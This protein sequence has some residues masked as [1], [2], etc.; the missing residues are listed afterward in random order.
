[1][2]II[3][4]F[5][6]SLFTIG[7]NAQKKTL[8]IIFGD[9]IDKTEV[10]YIE[11]EDEKYHIVNDTITIQFKNVPDKPLNIKIKGKLYWCS[12]E[13]I[14]KQDCGS[15]KM[16]IVKKKWVKNS[17]FSYI[18]ILCNGDNILSGL[19]KYTCRW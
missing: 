16:K 19:P 13:N 5:I 17:N 8:T 15:Y 3:F 6:I 12:L 1:M 18:L 14:K 10:E 4:I 11:Y 9:F 7:A 2:K